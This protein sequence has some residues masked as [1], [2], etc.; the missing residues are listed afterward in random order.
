MNEY[1]DNNFGNI[2]LLKKCI[3]NKDFDKNSESSEEILETQENDKR[4]QNS[5]LEKIENITNKENDKGIIKREKNEISKF[6]ENKIITTYN[7]K[8]EYK[9]EDDKEIKNSNE[10]NEN[11]VVKI[12]I[13]ND[14]INIKEKKDFQKLDINSKEEIILES[15]KEIKEIKTNNITNE[16][17]IN[18]KNENTEEKNNILVEKIIIIKNNEEKEKN[19]NNEKKINNCIQ[20]VERKREDLALI[21]PLNKFRTFNNEKS[22]NRIEEK[23]QYKNKNEK[24]LKNVNN[25]K[26]Q[27]DN[28]NNI[29][30]KKVDNNFRNN[31]QKE[32]SQKLNNKISLFFFSLPYSCKKQIFNP[33][34]KIFGKNVFI[35]FVKQ[36][37]ID[38]SK[39]KIPLLC[40]LCFN[41]RDEKYSLQKI[42]PPKLIMTQ[43]SNIITFI[44]HIVKDFKAFYNEYKKFLKYILFTFYKGLERQVRDDIIIITK[45][46]ENKIEKKN[47]LELA[48][49]ISLEFLGKEKK[50]FEKTNFKIETPKKIQKFKEIPK[51]EDDFDDEIS[52]LSNISPKGLKNLGSCC[53]MNATLQCFFHIKEFTTYFLKNKKEINKKDGLIT[54]GLLDLFEG[55]S[56]NDKKSYYIPQLFKDNLIEVDDLFGGG[57][58]KDSGDLVQTILTNCQEEL[59][60]ESDFPDF[61]IDRREERLMYLDLY[62]KNSQAPSIIMDL[63]NFETRLTC[64]CQKCNV[65]Y[66]NISCE[67]MLLFDL[68]GIYYFC[69]KKDNKKS[70]NFY[71]S[72]R[73]LSIDECFRSFSLNGSLRE[74]VVCK[75]C[76]KK[77]NIISKRD[78]V[79]LPKIFIMI[80]SRGSEEKFECDIDFKEE[81]DLKNFYNG[82]KG[83]KKEETTKYSLLAGT[84]LYGSRGY[85]HTVAFCKHFGSQ[86]YIFND[87]SVNKTYFNEIKKEKVYLLFYQKNID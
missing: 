80:M 24:K 20:I 81:L 23:Q 54:T 16:E 85:G 14:C 35:I 3:D 48:N 59:G 83:I 2:D 71:S 7:L 47:I 38:D 72:K 79:T 1:K 52:F 49:E 76:N 9:V 26:V 75:Y 30:S 32:I 64:T 74:N 17:E 86:Y 51:V 57:G 77:T 6:D 5:E 70:F 25:Y 42:Y 40:L 62:Y 56:K 12:K 60:E 21:Y 84:I 55:L 44:N 82:I 41:S 61:S 53:Y 36:I 4:S 87:S 37:Y 46:N 13:K 8:S 33:M 31:F 63:F 10:K 19:L 45:E 27:K 22:L 50:I 15:N 58:G 73:R 28:K 68:E 66:Y 11:D 43:I 78:F 67:N 29:I 34:I 65:K 69:H 18:L 39:L